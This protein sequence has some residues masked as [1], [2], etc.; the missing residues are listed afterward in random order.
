MTSADVEVGEI[1][2][3]YSTQTKP[4]KEKFHIC[5]APNTFLWINTLPNFPPA[6]PI[7]KKDYPFLDH[8]SYIGCSELS[9]YEADR[10]IPDA[11][12]RGK[13]SKQTAKAILAAIGAAKTLTP[14]QKKLVAQHLAPLA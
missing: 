10:F 12:R 13:L 4:K 9:E 1:L 6:I 7:A 2:H 14:I 3:F 5:I 8:D 11:A